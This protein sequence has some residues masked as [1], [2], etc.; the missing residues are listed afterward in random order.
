MTRRV[1]ITL[2]CLASIGGSCK[3]K[4]EPINETLTTYPIDSLLSIH[5]SYYYTNCESTNSYI[6]TILFLDGNCSCSIEEI[7]DWEILLNNKNLKNKNLKAIFILFGDMVYAHAIREVINSLT[8]NYSIYYYDINLN[9][10]SK[11][12]EAF[13]EIQTILEYNQELIACGSQLK[14]AN[15]L[16]HIINNFYDNKPPLNQ[17]N[18]S[19]P[20]KENLKMQQ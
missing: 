5:P 12:I 11:K 13:Y 15:H 2:I 16:K 17:L 8:I 1:V 14:N 7:I 6:N 20:R 9:N 19:L 3:T 10:K 18:T 4:P